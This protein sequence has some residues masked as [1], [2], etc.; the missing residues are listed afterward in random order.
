MAVLAI[1]QGTTS[2]R[3][4]L[5]EDSG[6][7]RIVKSVQHRQLYPKPGWVEHD[8]EEL[9]RSIQTCIDS[10]TGLSAV[11]IDNQGESCLAWDAETKKAISP[12][13]VWQDNRTGSVIDR[14]KAE[15]REQM[16]MILS[17]MRPVST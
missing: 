7:A 5:V 8:P 3:A 15:S 14:L 9:I 4:L 1:D 2:T 17:F 11:G 13:I 10:C 12:V 6:R 16:V